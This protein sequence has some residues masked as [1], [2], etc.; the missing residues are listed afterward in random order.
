MLITPLVSDFDLLRASQFIIVDEPEIHLHPS[1]QSKLADFFMEMAMLGKRILIE[2]HS[3]Y[4]IDKMI[5]LKLKH[6]L[7][8]QTVGLNWVKKSNGDSYIE[9][10]E[11]DDLGF[12]L[13][14]PE[15]FLS[16][17]KILVNE[18]SKI[19][20]RKLNEK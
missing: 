3:E 9:R 19:R 6:K 18:L 2:T 14:P 13:N 4:L 20:I 12:V 8:S 11:H 15:N 10:I 7:S 1:L 17:R 5:Y 16:E